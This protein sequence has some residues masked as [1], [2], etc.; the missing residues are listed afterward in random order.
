MPVHRVGEAVD[1]LLELPPQPGLSDAGR[2]GHEQ[3]SRLAPVDNRVVDIKFFDQNGLDIDTTTERKIEGVFFRED[4]RRV[5]LNEIGR[6]GDAENIAETYTSAFFKALRPEALPTIARDFNLVIDYANANVSAILPNILRRLDIDVVELNANLDDNRLFQTAQE[7]DEGMGRLARI[8]PVL[9]AHMG[10]RIDGGGERLFLVDDAGRQLAGTQALAAITAL[11]M[12]VAMSL[13][14]PPDNTSPS[15]RVA[16]RVC[17]RSHGT[18]SPMVRG[19]HNHLFMMVLVKNWWALALR[20][21]AQIAVA[22]M[23]LERH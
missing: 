16:T 1:V 15:Q 11:A 2:A 12:L 20:G 6:I 21:L 17:A 8:T 5:Y 14:S 9:D 7:F 19:L 18:A 22:P 4:Y 10:V 23:P 3:Q 13:A